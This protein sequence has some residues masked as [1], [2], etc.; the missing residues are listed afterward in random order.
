MNRRKSCNLTGYPGDDVH[1]EL[2]ITA[3]S[4][5]LGQLKMQCIVGSDGQPCPSVFVAA[6]KSLNAVAFQAFLRRH[7]LPRLKRTS[8]DGHYIF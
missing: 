2:P 1:Q 3:F 8:P 4:N 5:T 7:G 6:G